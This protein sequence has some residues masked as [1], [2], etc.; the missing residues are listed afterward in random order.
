MYSEGFNTSVGS[1]SY[2]TGK[3]CHWE[4]VDH[5]AKL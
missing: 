5:L 1:S 2:F 3:W 4:Y